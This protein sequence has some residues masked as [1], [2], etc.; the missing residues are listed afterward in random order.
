MPASTPTPSKHDSD[1]I[2]RPITFDV[3]KLSAEQRAAHDAIVSGPRGVVAG[4]LRTWLLSPTLANRAQAL[5]EF[6]RYHTTLGPSLS[7]LAILVTGSYWRAGYEWHAHAPIAESAGIDPKAIEAIRTGQVPALEGAQL[8]VYHFCRELLE[9]HGV[10]KAT[11]EDAVR[12]LG[13]QGVV[14]LVG[15]LG[16]YGLISMTIKAFEVPVPGDAVEP[17]ED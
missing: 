14:E 4:P 9:Q 12:A 10:K 2:Q 13:R 17:F 5:G 11:Y 8:V 1:Q 7:E 15:V 16:Y 3:N 6:C